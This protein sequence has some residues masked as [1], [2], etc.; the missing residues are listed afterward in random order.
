MGF[1]SFED[2]SSDKAKNISSSTVDG[3]SAAVSFVPELQRNGGVPILLEVEFDCDAHFRAFYDE[4][5]AESNKTLS[6]TVDGQAHGSGDDASVRELAVFHR[7]GW[8]AMGDD[9]VD[10]ALYMYHDTSYNAALMERTSRL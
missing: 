1:Q 10:L 6:T 4:S 7:D 9:P 2:T 5:S 8:D 3:M